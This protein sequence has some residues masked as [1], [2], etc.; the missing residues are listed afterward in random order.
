MDAAKAARLL[1]KA[2]RQY[3]KATG[4]EIDTVIL[5]GK[6]DTTRMSLKRPGEAM[7]VMLL[8]SERHVLKHVPE[9]GQPGITTEKLMHLCGYRAKS[10]FYKILRRLRA[11]GKVLKSKGLYTKVARSGTPLL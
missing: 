2:A 11:K 8:E 1:R 3:A 9:Y 10:N 5:E 6:S 4:A 7:K